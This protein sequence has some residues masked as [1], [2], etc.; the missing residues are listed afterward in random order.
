MTNLFIIQCICAEHSYSGGHSFPWNQK[1]CGNSDEIK[2][3][4]LSLAMN[5]P[6]HA[7]RGHGL[8]RGGMVSNDWCFKIEKELLCMSDF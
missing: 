4:Q 8:P 5:Q 1:H 2:A 3:L 7:P 6:S